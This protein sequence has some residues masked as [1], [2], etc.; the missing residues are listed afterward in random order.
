[1]IKTEMKITT[2]ISVTFRKTEVVQIS[3]NKGHTGV[4]EGKKNKV[5][6]SL[7]VVR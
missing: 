4:T 7:C 6:E 1:V 3:S 5:T 2:F